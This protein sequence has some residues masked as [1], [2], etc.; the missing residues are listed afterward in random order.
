MGAGKHFYMDSGFERVWV[1]HF[2]DAFLG[3]ILGPPICRK[4]PTASLGLK[5]ECH[6][7]V[8]EMEGFRL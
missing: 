2:V 3:S 7:Q 6:T 8:K 5:S 1:P 4:E